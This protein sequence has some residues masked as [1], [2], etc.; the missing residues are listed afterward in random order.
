VT[1]RLWN[2]AD[3]NLIQTFSHHS[4]DVFS[5]AFSPDGAWFASAGEDKTVGLWRLKTE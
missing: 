5:V 3:G 4:D 1:V 2:S